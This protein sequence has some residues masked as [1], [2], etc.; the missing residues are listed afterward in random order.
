MCKP[1]SFRQ[2]PKHTCNHI[3]FFIVFF[4]LQNKENVGLPKQTFTSIDISMG[5]IGLTSHTQFLFVTLTV[6]KF[7]LHTYPIHITFDQY[8]KLLLIRSA[9]Q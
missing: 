7:R 2:L 5:I 1:V 6:L 4:L 9:F 3:T 8:S